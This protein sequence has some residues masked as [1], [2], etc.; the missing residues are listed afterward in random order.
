MIFTHIYA[1]MAASV[2]SLFSPLPRLSDVLP[3]RSL[4]KGKVLFS[5]WLSSICFQPMKIA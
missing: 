5:Y 3:K 1:M 2:A 4:P